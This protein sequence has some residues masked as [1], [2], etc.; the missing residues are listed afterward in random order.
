MLKDL[1]LIRFGYIILNSGR[2]I[3]HL[4]LW[5][6]G[7]MSY[8]YSNLLRYC[9]SVAYY[10]A[11]PGLL[12]RLWWRSLRYHRDYRARWLERFGAVPRLKNPKVIWV[13]AVSMGETLAAA[14]L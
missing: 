3:Y 9:Y 10:I 6:Y 12:L 4:Y 7:I 5:Y 1:N 2:L 8:F 14:P 11:V 13:H